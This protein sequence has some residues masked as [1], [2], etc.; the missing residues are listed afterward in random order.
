VRLGAALLVLLGV[1]AAPALAALHAVSGVPDT[2][3]PDQLT[4]V[5]AG[6][7]KESVAYSL[8][9][10]FPLWY[11]DENGLTLEL[12]LDQQVVIVPGTSIFPCLTEEPFLGAPISFPRN[13]GAEA[14]WWGAATFGTFRSSIDIGLPTPVLVAGEALFFAGV[15]AGF[16]ADLLADGNQASRSRIHV[17]LEPALNPLLRG[18]YRVTHPYGVAIYEVDDLAIQQRQDVGNLLDLAH[19]APP[20]SGPAPTGPPPVGDFTLA[21]PDGPEPLGDMAPGLPDIGYVSSVATGIGP[22]L[23]PAD[24]QER[25]TAL[26]GRTYLA[27]PWTVNEVAARMVPVT[28]SPF[29][30]NFFRIELLDP[31]PGVFLNAGDPAVVGDESQVLEFDLFQVFG[32]IFD[33]RANLRPVAHDDE[34]RTLPGAPVDIDV[35]AND[36][37][38]VGANNVHGLNPLALGLPRGDGTI[39][40]TRP[41]ATAHGTVER[42]TEIAS[43]RTTFVYTPNDPGFTGVDTFQYVV[44]DR[45]GLVSAPATVTVT[46]A[47]VTV[48][49]AEYRARTGKWHIRGTTTDASEN[50]VA[51]FGGPRA[52]FAAVPGASTDALGGMG[53]RVTP[54]EIEFGLALD[55]LPATLVTEIQLRAPGPDGPLLFTLHDLG[56]DAP[57]TGTKRGTLT[58][59]H[60]DPLH[61]DFPSFAQAVE[62]ILA[63]NAYVDV[64]TVENPDGELQGRLVMPA[65]GA[66]P[67]DPATGGWVFSGKA[68]VSPGGA[69]ASVNALSSNGFWTLGT[70]LRFR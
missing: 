19:G 28:G 15:E 52:G 6:G 38:V 20:P 18:T 23:V 60:L 45:G 21:L 35:V 40:L 42:F 49:A 64:R 14:L 43:G 57:F 5:L 12:C 47:D 66:A 65:I 39:L 36:E 22:F 41:L 50:S 51:L 34:A 9:N 25:I 13:F 55:P 70:P 67:V 33:G 46:I 59:A 69:P 24:P 16:A 1:A 37:D 29:G 44:Q 32:K 62:W 61:P 10:G 63:G 8:A 4:E 11:R 53:L 58:E 17:H 3:A 26:D 2:A 54:T 30:T 68:T 7:P 48:A 31:Q 56:V 27:N